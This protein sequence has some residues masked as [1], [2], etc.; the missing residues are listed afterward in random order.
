MK[1]C[2]KCGYQMK[3]T[4]SFCAKC[5]NS[6][7]Y[8]VQT[9]ETVD[10]DKNPTQPPCETS[11]QTVAKIFMLL[12]TIVAGVCSCGIALCWMIPMTVHYWNAL[13]NGEPVGT[14]FKVCSLIFVS[15]IAGI[16]MLCD[17]DS[18]VR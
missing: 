8:F 18:N 15:L 9:S 17:N 10:F 14:G 1:F 2:S 7:D 11:L 6:S 3:D 5:G 13:K 16:L 12:E 4:D